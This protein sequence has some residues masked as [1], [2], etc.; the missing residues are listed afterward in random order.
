MDW[1][2][3]IIV[4]LTLIVLSLVIT[5][6]KMEKI[7]R[8]LNIIYGL[9][10]Q[11]IGAYNALYGNLSNDDISRAKLILSSKQRK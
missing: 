8:E 4:G 11:I 10:L 7:I 5:I 6:V 1:Y 3:F 2:V 9:S